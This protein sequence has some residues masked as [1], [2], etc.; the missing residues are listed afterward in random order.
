MN[1]EVQ[2]L[3][4]GILNPAA[5]NPRKKLKPGDKTYEDIKRSMQ[6]FGL[7]QNLIWNKRTGNLIAGHQR[8]TVGKREFGWKQ[9]PCCVVDLPI[10]QEKALNVVMNKVGEGN[11]SMTKLADLLAELGQN[12]QIELTDLGFSESELEALLKKP[13][14]KT[15]RD[16]DDAPPPPRNPKTKPGDLYHIIS[17]D[18]HPEHRLICGSALERETWEK[19]LGETRPLM[20]FTDPPYGVS[21]QSKSKSGKMAKTDIQNDELQRQALQDF[22][23]PAFQLAHEF[24]APEAS[25][26]CFFATRE[27]IAFE[28]ALRKAEWN[29]T[30][31]LIWAKQMNLGRSN[32]HWAHEPCQP[33][34]TMVE[35][36][37]FE[38]LGSQPAVTEHVPIETLTT[39]DKVV[40]FEPKAQIIKRRGRQV[41][42]IGSRQ[43][44]GMMHAI[45]VAGKTTRATTEHR[46]SARFDKSQRNRYCLYLMRSGPRWRLGITKLYNSRGFGLAVRVSQE[47]A[48]EAWIL[49]THENKIE[50]A[51]AEQVAQCRYGIPTTHW[52]TANKPTG[53]Q[54]RTDDQ[55]DSI[56]HQLDGGTIEAGAMQALAD[57]GRDPRFPIVDSR[58]I[59]LFSRSRL[60]LLRASNLIEGVTQLPIPTGGESYEWETITSNQAKPFNGEVWSI[61]VDRDHHYIADGIVTHNC[62]YGGKAGGQARWY[63]DRCQ[64]TMWQDDRPDFAS[65]KKEALVE[66]LTGLA[67]TTTVWDEKRD[68]PSSYIH[69]CLPPGTMV[70]TR[71]GWKPIE[72]IRPGELVMTA[73]GTF[74]PVTDVSHH[75]GADTLWTITVEG[76]EVPATGNH[77]F[78]IWR[79]GWIMWIEAAQ[80]R[81][82]DYTLTPLAFDN[83]PDTQKPCRDART[84]SQPPDQS[85]RKDTGGSTTRESDDSACNTSSSG[86]PPTDQS[87]P[88]LKSTIG[89]TISRTT[90][91]RTLTWSMPL[92]TS[93]CTRLARSEMEFGGSPARPAESSNQQP[94]PIG[95]SAGDGST[96]ENA[97]PASAS[98]RLRKSSFAAHR[99]ESVTSAKYSGL[100]WNLTVAESPTFLTQIGITH[101]TQKPT[102]LVRRAMRHSTIPRDTTVD[103][104][105]GSGSTMI[106]GQLQGRATYTIEL[107]PGFCDAIIQRYV[108]TFQECLLFRNGEEIDPLAFN[109]SLA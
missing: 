107:E 94:S 12:P 63:G 39:A 85:R 14:A 109:H 103:F 84:E 18:G 78:L 67:D 23:L 3:D 20:A 100:V 27:H 83:E 30:Q 29:P 59:G 31:E 53:Q 51:V 21:Y 75:G 40:S 88:D 90:A 70:L 65:M 44:D 87:P 6:D 38:G 89:T 41:T 73:D 57:H 64:T 77:P 104:F 82:G 81:P 16:P 25:I 86:K 101:N 93:G 13:T 19:L 46:F 43:Y 96:G 34:G 74:Q 47:Q 37:I 45:T 106:G 80:I 108:E 99:V 79:D 92:H 60:S 68:P 28:Q 22:L 2:M 35:K 11:W 91:Y 15:N 36:V 8:L 33:A 32:Y 49:S 105:G 5:Y 76:I 58:V 52:I 56:Y 42:S 71:T 95:I 72:T 48:D 4:V 97:A 55:I 50:G 17:A 1:F 9:A 66:I 69:P 24:T 98:D 102:S 62:F 10:E 7:V 54:Q 26:Y 61:D